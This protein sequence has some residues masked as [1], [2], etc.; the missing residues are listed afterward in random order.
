MQL[1]CETKKSL[2][3]LQVFKMIRYD[4]RLQVAVTIF[5]TQMKMKIFQT[6]DPEYNVA[7]R[8]RAKS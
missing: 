6:G 1:T 7:E 2:L 5:L 8:V 3:R 4:I